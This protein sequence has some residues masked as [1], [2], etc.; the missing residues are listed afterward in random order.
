MHRTVLTFN[1]RD[2]AR[3]HREYVSTGKHHVGIIVS[4]QLQVGVIVRRLLKLLA[5]LSAA[6]MRDRLEYLGN[7][8]SA[9][10][11]AEGLPTDN[12]NLR[13]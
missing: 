9:A 4:D 6:D 12:P 10:P 11:Q 1:V 5:S 2:Y 13:A 8:R 7:W 3:L